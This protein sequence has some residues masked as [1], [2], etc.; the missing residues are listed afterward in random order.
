MCMKK[1]TKLWRSF[2][3]ISMAWAAISVSGQV[4]EKEKQ[5]QSTHSMGCI[6]LLG[7]ICWQR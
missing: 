3:L 7:I 1:F 4:V 5:Y 6:R 2:L